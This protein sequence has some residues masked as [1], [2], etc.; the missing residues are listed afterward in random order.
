MQDLIMGE[1]NRYVARFRALSEA[2][3]QQLQSLAAAVE[4][5]GEEYEASFP[6]QQSA[7]AAAMTLVGRGAELLEIH[8][9]RLSLEEVFIEAVGGIPE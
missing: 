6:D 8:P 1:E 7:A 9:H 5:E 3:R 2:T 4:Q